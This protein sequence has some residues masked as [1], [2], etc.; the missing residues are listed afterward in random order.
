MKIQSKKI[1]RKNDDRKEIC[2]KT[3]GSYRVGILL[4]NKIN[5]TKKQFQIRKIEQPKR[6][7][8]NKEG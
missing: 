3:Y 6:N 8:H 2:S 4:E 1:A 7:H 5:K